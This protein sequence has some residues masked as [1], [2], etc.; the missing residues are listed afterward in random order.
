MAKEIII[1]AE[2]DQTRIAIVEDGELVE[3]YIE[4]P[5]HERTIGNIYLARVCRIMPNIQAVFVDIG[6]KQDAF[7]HFSDISP[8]LPLQLKFLA[9]P[10]PS[11]QK[12]AAEIEA[13]HQH[14]TRRRH[15][16]GHLA[17]TANGEGEE[18]HNLK[19]APDEPSEAPRR[20]RLDVL[21]R[22]R[23][24]LAQ[25]RLKPK[26]AETAGSEKS[27]SEAEP[28]ETA[29]NPP[30]A[31]EALLKRDQPLLVKIIKEPIS[32]K[33]SR[34]STDISLAGRFL[35]LVPFASYVAVSKK[36]YLLQRTSA[37]AGFGSQLGSRRVWRHCPHGG[38]RPKRQSPRYGFAPAPGKMAKD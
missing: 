27:P 21:I 23:R 30:F 14:L 19:T 24:R 22:S 36:D 26:A 12:L 9:D 35:V 4:D 29:S 1:N 34:V 13:H 15:P 25:R 32:S 16:R 7:L 33:G 18:D 8:S 37:L 5:E 11:V 3:F 38:R 17:A 2:K 10:Q 28:K 6:Q 31:P 20:L